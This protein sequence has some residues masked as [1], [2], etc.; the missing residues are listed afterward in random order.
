MAKY[1]YVV[2]NRSGVKKEG[3]L[4]ANNVDNARKKLSEDYPII[5]SVTEASSGKPKFWQKPSLSMQ[6]KLLFTKHM[7][8]MIKVGITVT[9]AIKILIGQTLR[10]SL[11]QMYESILEMVYSGQS[12]SQSLR[13]YEDVFDE[14]YV[15]ILETGEKTGSLEQ[16]FHN[17][18]VQLEKDYELRKK[19]ISAFIYPAII[20]VLTVV[21]TFGIIFFIMPKI[22]KIFTS[23][24]I[25]LPFITQFLIDF[26]NFIIEKPLLTILIMVGTATALVGIFK[27]KFLKPFWQR[28]FIVIPVFGRVIIYSNLARFN[29]AMHTLLGSGVNIGEALSIASKVTNNVLY[30]RAIEEARQKVEQGGKLGE[31]LEDKPFIFPPLTTKT[32]SIGEKTGS[33]DSTTGHL[34]KMYEHNVEAITRNLSVLL[35][36]ILLIFMAAMV[37]T[38][39][40]AIILPIYQLPNLISQ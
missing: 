28:F 31:S 30:K 39:V 16:S 34:A 13:Q 2:S 4:Y 9:E 14:L 32:L 26:S 40:L 19:V 22:T 3:T 5:I 11:R 6:D 35:E 33:L 7:Y 17:L 27:L 36:P 25:D 18:D 8:T 23:F 24:D 38:I 29:R 10:P 20:I 1:K 37:G 12:L 21:I 15:N